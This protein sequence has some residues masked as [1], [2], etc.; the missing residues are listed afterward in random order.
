M[1]EAVLTMLAVT[2]REL[3]KAVGLQL[4]SRR[5]EKHWNPIDVER[6]GGPNYATVQAIERGNVGRVDKLELHAKALG[7]DLVDL[8]AT[9]LA[10]TTQ[11]LTLEERMIVRGYQAARVR[12]RRALVALAET[13]LEETLP[14]STE[15]PGVVEPNTRDKPAEPVVIRG[16]TPKRGK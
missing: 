12:G 10:P 14:T 11:P 7:V 5:M 13:L 2:E 1:R 8:L 9:I 16:R 6:H 4:V 3:W 15:S